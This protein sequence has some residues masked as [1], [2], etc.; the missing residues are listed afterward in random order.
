MVD[1]VLL[2]GKMLPTAPSW[3]IQVCAPDQYVKATDI[4]LE[5]F[6]IGGQSNTTRSFIYVVQ[7]YGYEDEYS[8]IH[9]LKIA[10]CAETRVF[11]DGEGRTYHAN[12]NIDDNPT[13]QHLINTFQI[14]ID[15]TQQKL[16]FG[17]R[18]HI[19]VA[20]KDRQGLGIG[21]YC[22]SK[23]IEHALKKFPDY[24]II[25][26]DLSFEDARDPINHARR[27]SFYKNLGFNVNTNNRGEG[28]FS[29]LSVK[30]L[31]TH[32]NPQKV[33]DI[34]PIQLLKVAL[35]CKAKKSEQEGMIERLQAEVDKNSNK[36]WDLYR[37]KSNYQA[38]TIFLLTLIPAYFYWF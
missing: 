14:V 2:E 27:D 15:K 13:Y 19:I 31:K 35:D 3:L 1:E 10:E 28:K 20:N 9:A 29:A 36:Y 17:P 21:S 37:K 22:M 8:A 6:T 12:Y 32:Y 23:L 18:G 30:Q 25:S 24:K 26:G 38:T 5:P 33:S 4:D 34:D 7:Q 16:R 11:I